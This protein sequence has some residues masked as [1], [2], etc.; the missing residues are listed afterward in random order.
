MT[1]RARERGDTGR[2]G[3]QAPGDGGRA[4]VHAAE[5][6][7]FADAVRERAGA[8]GQ[9]GSVR[10]SR[11]ALARVRLER[12]S[13]KVSTTIESICAQ[14]KVEP[15]ETW[16]RRQIADV[17]I[18]QICAKVTDGDH[19][20]ETR[21][22]TATVRR[23]QAEAEALAGAALEAMARPGT[24]HTVF[25]ALQ[26]LRLALRDGRWKV[27]PQR[28]GAL[29]QVAA[30]TW[31][32]RERPCRAVARA[33]G[34]ESGSDATYLDGI[35][36]LSVS[37]GRWVAPH[38]DAAAE[39]TRVALTQG[40]APAQIETLLRTWPWPTAMPP[41]PA[42]AA[43][44]EVGRNILCED[45]WAAAVTLE[46]VDAP[47]KAQALAEEIEALA[48]RLREIVEDAIEAEACE[49]LAQLFFDRWGETPEART[50]GEMLERM[51]VLWARSRRLAPKDD[52]EHV[53]R[54]VPTGG[55][56]LVTPTLGWLPESLRGA[57]H[58]PPSLAW[59]V[60]YTDAARALAASNAGLA[61]EAMAERA[62]VVSSPH[63]RLCV[64]VGRVQGWE[65]DYEACRDRAR[66]IDAILE[67]LAGEF[68]SARK[69]ARAPEMAMR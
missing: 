15:D 37:L 62:G 44:A 19:D 63:A 52:A 18:A 3:R 24:L 34:R 36:T 23:C 1:R 32:A 29:A 5:A 65:P 43:C 48:P 33:L 22:I 40:P 11:A 17:V 28:L 61:Y 67:Q 41:L 7:A 66:A 49:Q 6:R 35:E 21:A 13:E 25:G 14:T 2:N 31:R 8:I 54:V 46:S 45:E 47:I 30:K 39:R 69:H 64:K 51:R 27:A 20:E 9:I 50:R 4:R 58:D 53:L 38:A 12:A 10:R 26:R 60:P 57:I 55:Q 68:E 59:R 16:A 56:P 42:A